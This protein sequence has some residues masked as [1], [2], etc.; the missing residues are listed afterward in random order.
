MTL[1]LPGGKKDRITCP[2]D[3]YLLDQAEMEGVDL[4]YTCRTGS[5]NSC[6]AKVVSGSVAQSDRSFLS[7]ELLQEGFCLL[8]VTYP[9][10]DCEIETHM[11]DAL[12]ELI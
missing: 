12:D 10:S 9:S 8:C 7:D 4:P 11:E 5:C 3:Q 1:L 2:G 6:A